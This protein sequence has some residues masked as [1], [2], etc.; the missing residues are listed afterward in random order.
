MAEDHTD[1]HN[2]HTLSHSSAW[3]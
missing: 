3:I 1:N 2:Q